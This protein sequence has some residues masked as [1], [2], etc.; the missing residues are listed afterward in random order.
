ML[1]IFKL[2][3][4]LI[5]PQQNYVNKQKDR[6]SGISWLYWLYEIKCTRFTAGFVSLLFDPPSY[7]I[8]TF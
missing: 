7:I 5:P 8:F 2:L 1:P 4:N 3:C 6:I